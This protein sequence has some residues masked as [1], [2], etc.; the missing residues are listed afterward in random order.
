MM[1]VIV[2]GS[3]GFVGGYLAS[4]LVRGGHE[5]LEVDLAAT[6]RPDRTGSAP[7]CSYRQCDLTD[8]QSVLSLIGEEMPGGI[9]HLAAQS[10][11]ARSFDDPVGT[12]RANILGALNLF[13]ADKNAKTKARILIT[14]SCDEY[15]VRRPEEMPLGEDSPIEPVSPYASSKA[16]QNLLAMQYF[17]AFGTRVVLTRSF[18][19][20]GAGQPDRF[21]L[22]AFARQCAA[23]AAGSAE[24]VVK[25]GNTGV[26][27]D[28]LDVRDVVR[29]YRLLLEKGVE[30]RVYNVCS[31]N[32][33]ALG[34]ALDSLIAMT[35]TDVR[36]EVDP[37]LA[38]PVDVPVLTGDNCRLAKDTGWEVQI[39]RERMLGDLFDWWLS[40]SA[41]E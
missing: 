38:R 7:G 4:E 11:A 23:I 28:F 12:Y 13:E 10:S 36:K 2:T 24:P 21:V 32:G 33:L 22:P 40:R 14:G 3:N 18:S 1:K 41:A 31:G 16:A 29:A 39:G 20:T 37:A 30:G 25:T 26:V 34:E 19:H 35:G 9:I 8:E 5:V 17:R 6:A 15:G 27:R